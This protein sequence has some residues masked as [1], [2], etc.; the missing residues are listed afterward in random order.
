MVQHNSVRTKIILA[1]IEIM[2]EQG[3]QSL[4]V[5][6]IAQRADVNI[7]AINYHFGSKDNLIEIALHQTLDQAFVDMINEELN[8]P[9]RDKQEA[10]NAFFMAL[11]TGLRK[12][13]GLTKAH[14]YDPLMQNDY[15]GAFAVRFQ[16]FLSDLHQK[17]KE[18]FPEMPDDELRLAIMEIISAIIFP[19]LLSGLFEEYTGIDFDDPD[20]QSKYVEHLVRHYFH[21]D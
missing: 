5:R 8:L 14:L 12:F 15:R 4:T 7:A 6:E 10:L 19:G 20:D 21:L 17:C 13:P 18:F 3:I 9:G 1:T 16:L 2:E 11:L